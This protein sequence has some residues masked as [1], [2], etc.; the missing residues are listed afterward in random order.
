[1]DGVCISDGIINATLAGISYWRISAMR[2]PKS[3]MS[4][5]Y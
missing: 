3:P 5:D 4:G 1:V 2:W